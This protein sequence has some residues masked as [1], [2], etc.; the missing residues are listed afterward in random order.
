MTTARPHSEGEQETDRATHTKKKNTVNDTF[1]QMCSEL[2]A[3]MK[4]VLT[5]PRH[6]LVT[7]IHASLLSGLQFSHL[8][9]V[10]NISG[11]FPPN[12][13]LHWLIPSLSTKKYRSFLR[14][15]R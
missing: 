6:E 1:S 4:K 11:P 8:P 7:R 10:V 13:F 9:Y 12:L 3:Y 5:T 15:W 2:L 14:I